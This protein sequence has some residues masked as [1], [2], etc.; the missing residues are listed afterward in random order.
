MLR[1]PECRSRRT[2]YTSMQRHINASGHKLCQCGGYPYPHR[3]GSP[4]CEQ[5]PMAPALAASRA[6]ESDEAV[7]EIAIGIAL[8]VAGKPLKQWPYG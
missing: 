2:T 4:Y 7:Q 1:C 5:N 3:P 6:G 8:A